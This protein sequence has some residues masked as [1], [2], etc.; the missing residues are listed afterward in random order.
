MKK[1][2]LLLFLIAAMVTGAAYAAE[3]SGY[4]VKLSADAPA[5][6]SEGEGGLGGGFYRL[7]SRETVEGLA[8]LGCVEF[9]EP[10]Y[11]VSLCGDD[12]A[13]AGV[14]PPNDPY[15]RYDSTYSQWNLDMIG[16]GAAWNSGY[17]GQGVRVG[18]I[19][20]GLAAAHEDM[21]YSH[22]L[23]GVNTVV[24][25]EDPSYTDT[26]DTY[27]HGSFVSGTIAAQINNSVGVAGITDQ[28][29]LLPIKA[30][31]GKTTSLSYVLKGIY[32]AIDQ[33]CDVINMSFSLDNPASS[34]K[35]AI[36]E[37]V[38]KGILVVAAVGNDGNTAASYPA[39]F[40]GVVGVGSVNADYQL[41][42]FSQRNESVY[43]V[44]PGAKVLSIGYGTNNYVFGS[45]TSYATPCVA[46]FAV[47]AKQFCKE[48]GY[49]SFAALLRMTALDLGDEG[50]DTS[51][52]YGLVSVPAFL[53]ALEAS[54]IIDLELEGGSFLAAAPPRAYRA[55]SGDIVLPKVYRE[56]YTFE[57][58]Y[59]D[60]AHTIPVEGKIPAGS[61]GDRAFYA[62]WVENSLVD[63][64]VSGVTVLGYPGEPG[65]TAQGPAYTVY[66]PGGTPLPMKAEDV[67]VTCRNPNATVSCTLLDGGKRLYVEVTSENGVEKAAFTVL[68]D[69]HTFYQPRR[70][71]A[72]QVGTAVP[73]SLDGKTAAQPYQADLSEWFSISSEELLTYQMT[74]ALGKVDGSKFTFLPEVTDTGQ[75]YTVQITAATA[76]FASEPVVLTLAV[77]ALPEDEPAVTP[78]PVTPVSNPTRVRLLEKEGVV[79]YCIEGRSIP[80]A[81]AKLLA[82]HNQENTVVLS[83]ERV[84]AV[85]PPGMLTADHAMDFLPEWPETLAGTGSLT[86]LWT[87]EDGNTC[88]VAVS[89]VGGDGTVCFVARGTGRYEVTRIACP[90]EDVTLSNA[91]AEAIGFVFARGILLG[92]SASTFEPEEAMTRGMLATVLYRLEGMPEPENTGGF[93]DVAPD[94]WYAA[95]ADW[96]LGAGLME[97]VGARRF[98]PEETVSAEQ[99]AVTLYRYAERKG[100]AGERIEESRNW[101]GDGL[102]WAQENGI[103]YTSGAVSRGEIAVALQRLVQ[104]RLSVYDAAEGPV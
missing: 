13:L 59:A 88:P 100:M 81:D 42:A 26:T 65:D 47:M 56:G 1:I 72:E 32:Q 83:G 68:V 50:Y 41:S 99:L 70:L 61:V 25:E 39:A 35:Y 49:E 80:A 54:Y 90:F 17:Y 24:D 19:D 38:S 20:S 18:V 8:E 6:L 78:Q 69:N 43:V 4:I 14:F 33:G 55:D 23:P 40:E 67:A 30:F 36:D 71:M 44:A 64:T 15:Y 5:P 103:V 27:G 46:A 97:G 101:Y 89:E 77:G 10:D 48:I 28:V 21:D 7:N 2:A 75:V 93:V 31:H 66:L 63:T 58:W 82:A 96:A 95:A 91:A 57:G 62:A 60:A 12:P 73:A 53:A 34:L 98:L 79:T 74:P 92:T 3:E 37:A 16:V 29:E 84:Q 76:R 9:V 94:A 102:S 104:Y 51:Y 11:E 22:I 45:G 86:L 87:D 85:I 52:G